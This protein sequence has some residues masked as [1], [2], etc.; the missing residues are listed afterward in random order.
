[1]PPQV[2][3]VAGATGNINTNFTGKAEA[4]LTAFRTGADFVYL[5]IEAA[6]EAGHHGELET[7]IAAIERIDQEVLGRILRELPVISPEYK[8]L[9]L[10]DHPTPL[11]VKTHVADPVPFVIY[12]SENKQTG[13]SFPFDE[14]SAAR[15]GLLI[16]TGHTLMDRFLLG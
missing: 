4:T 1:M 7:K 8:I 10:P 3:K 5:H 15:T 14:A 11:Q 12:S 16:E 6:D 2:I 9:L 13:S